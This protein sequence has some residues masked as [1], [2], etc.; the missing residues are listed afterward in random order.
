MM[1]K[2]LFRFGLSTVLML[3]A[4]LT[5]RAD[6]R[7]NSQDDLAQFDRE[8]R[9]SPDFL[10]SLSPQPFTELFD[11]LEIGIVGRYDTHG[12]SFLMADSV[13]RINGSLIF[14]FP[15]SFDIST[16]SSFAYADSDTLNVDPQFSSFEIAGN[17]IRLDLDTLGTLPADSSLITVT[18]DSILSPRTPGEYYIVVSSVDSIGELIAG[19]T[20]SPGF[21]IDPDELASIAVSPSSVQTVNA[22]NTILYSCQGWDQFA[23]ELTD[24]VPFW[25]VVPAVPLSDLAGEISEDGVFLA[26][27]RGTSRIVCQVDT[28]TDTSALVY[29]FP[30]EFDRYEVTGFPDH[31]LAGQTLTDSIFVAAVDMYG[32]VLSETDDTV[33]FVTTDNL[34]AISPNNASPH[35]FAYGDPAEAAFPG[36][37]YEF[38]TAGLHNIYLTNGTVDSDVFNIFVSSGVVHSYS[39]STPT[40]VTA[41]QPFDIEVVNV[42]DIAGNLLDVFVSVELVEP[43]ESPAGDLPDINSFAAPGGIGSAEQ[44]LV[45]AGSA[46]IRVDVGGKTTTSGIIMVSNASSESF[47]FYVSSP[48]FI[49]T[50]FTDSASIEV[51]DRYGNIAV[52]FSASIDIV[53][54]QPDGGGS[55][56]PSI[57]DSDTAFVDGFCD[58]MRFG[59]QYEGEELFLTFTATSESGVSGRSNIIAMHSSNLERLSVEPSQL[60]TSD[61]LTAAISIVNYGSLPTVVD[62]LSLWSTQGEMTVISQSNEPPYIITPGS[63]HTNTVRTVIPDNFDAGWTKFRA[64]F[65]GTYNELP[66]YDESEYLDSAKILS[67]ESLAYYES[68]LSPT[69]VSQGESYS[70]ICEVVHFGE[71]NIVLDTSSFMQFV[72]SASDTFEINLDDPAYIPAINEPITM[73]FEERVIESQY[74]SGWFTVQL[75]LNGLQGFSG[76]GDTITLSDSVLIQTPSSLVYNEGSF[77]PAEAFLG[78][79]IAPSLTVLNNGEA[80]LVLDTDQSVLHLTSTFDEIRFT[81]ADSDI[82]LQPGPNLLQFNAKKV[83]SSFPLTD[84]S[85]S[86]DING[87]EN[88]FSRTQTLSLGDNLIDFQQQA[89]VRLVSVTAV[90]QNIPKVN[91]QQSFDIVIRVA[92]EGDEDIE[93]VWIKLT[94]DG[95]S[96]F[97]DTYSIDSIPIGETD[98]VIVEVRASAMPNPA[99]LFTAYI[100]SAIGADTDLSGVILSPLDNTAAVS[101]QSPAE[102]AVSARIDSPPNAVDGVLSIGQSFHITTGFIN[103]GQA[104]VGY[105]LVNLSLKDTGFETDDDSLVAFAVDDIIGWTVT[106]PMADVNREIV[107]E[108][109]DIPADSNT[110]EPAVVHTGSVSIPVIVQKEELTLQ[111][112]Y[113]FYSRELVSPGEKFDVADLTCLALAGNPEAEIRLDEISFNLLDRHGNTAAANELLIAA[114]LLH[115][116]QAF[117]GS[118]SGSNVAFSFGENLIFGPDNPKDLTFTCTVN[119]DFASSSFFIGLDSTSVTATDV[120]YGIEG[121]RVTVVG[122]DGVALAALIGYG[123]AANNLEE[124]FFNYPNP[125]A[126][127]EEETNIVYFLPSPADVTIEIFTLIGEKVFSEEINSGELGAVSGEKNIIIW[128]GRNSR[129]DIVRNGVYI[130]VLK[131]STGTEARRKIAVAK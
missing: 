119:P 86:L 65:D 7:L 116:G 10:S 1:K 22:G 26:K 9:L 96:D 105:G 71:D 75:N 63:M 82:I 5:A 44:T 23:N 53:T 56:S 27:L 117:Q 129:G 89:T 112:T 78:T 39:F 80:S 36:T 131:L 43:G 61:T 83:P 21:V 18:L 51:F 45:L 101:I 33:W 90:S 58:L 88:G 17:S 64:S 102:I 30:G 6:S 108:L 98:S 8:I 28:F 2:E 122:G 29:V 38:R 34:A 79:E 49:S 68:S 110:G 120:T 59:P 66:V 69:S 77:Q 12:V 70:F 15:D 41:G 111:I 48:Q 37:N 92:N 11:S 126:A 60:Y 3:I 55:I 118:L 31:I 72:S 52:D 128:E 91:T 47:E 99:E 16:M 106:A 121:S 19:P 62:D 46:Q 4:A 123:S 81:L 20:V 76:Y 74:G 87:V 13:I 114:E 25:E 73:F 42:I 67:K 94:S 127:G 14:T 40:S 124:S 125:F 107:V 32:N 100:D 93:S 54:I 35:V 85:L 109:I 84:N 104:S 97:A 130:A 103:S 50:P 113:D 57:I 115:D 24:F 95:S